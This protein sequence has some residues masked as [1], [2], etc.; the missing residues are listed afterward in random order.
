MIIK[1]KLYKTA[2]VS[3][4]IVLMLIS[5]AGAF[6][7]CGCGYGCGD[8][9]CDH[10]TN[11]KSSDSSD[12]KCIVCPG[13]PTCPA[14]N[15]PTCPAPALSINKA[16]VLANNTDGSP[17]NITYTYIITNIGNI[18]VSGIVLYDNITSPTGTPVNTPT[19]LNP[20]D[21]V[22]VSNVVYTGL[23]PATLSDDNLMHGNVTNLAFTTA[24]GLGINVVSNRFP[25][26]IYYTYPA[27]PD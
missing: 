27:P 26:T 22:T 15:C 25:V 10:S 12:H 4:A 24:N 9:S 23:F 16:G 5:T 20:N 2:L 17:I 6:P 13:C 14:C 7:F 11:D 19:L 18:P 3:V 21:S 8:H 1:P